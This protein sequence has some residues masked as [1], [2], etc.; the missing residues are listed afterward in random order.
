MDNDDDYG[1]YDFPYRPLHPG[2]EAF[3]M[4]IAAGLVIGIGGWALYWAFSRLLTFIQ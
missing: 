2:R 3:T 4:V 1:A